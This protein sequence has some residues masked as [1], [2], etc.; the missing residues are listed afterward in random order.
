MG[1]PSIPFA[2]AFAVVV[3][4]TRQHDST[5]AWTA[6]GCLIS[7]SS[8]RSM[9]LSQQAPITAVIGL[10]ASG[11]L[12]V[13]RDAGSLQ[14][15]SHYL[16]ISDSSVHGRHCSVLHFDLAP[17]TYIPCKLLA[18]YRRVANLRTISNP[19]LCPTHPR[20]SNDLRQASKRA[21]LGRITSHL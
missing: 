2:V 7:A 1:K 20:H 6:E 15:H 10:Q 14:L 17:Q 18:S 5:T 21:T 9:M 16:L 13:P 4:P 8:H 3:T 19:G 11:R 12:D